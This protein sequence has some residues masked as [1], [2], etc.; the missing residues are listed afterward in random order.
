MSMEVRKWEDMN[1]DCLTNVFERVGWEALV[2]HLPLVCK[3]WYK[4]SLHPQFWKNLD[5]VPLYPDYIVSTKC[6]V[7]ENALLPDDILNLFSVETKY[8]DLFQFPKDIMVKV[9]ISRSCGL[10]TKLVV[11]Y[12][13]MVDW[14]KDF[15]MGRRYLKAEDEKPFMKL[16]TTLRSLEVL[17]LGTFGCYFMEILAGISR[18]CKNF[19]ALSTNGVIFEEEA[20]AIV[21][22]LPSIKYLKLR[23]SRISHN[24][25]MVI[26][27]GCKELV[28]LDVSDCTGFDAGDEVILNLASRIKNFIS[29]GSSLL[30]I[31]DNY[32]DHVVD[33]NFLQCVMKFL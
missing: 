32:F 28:L 15:L 10:A 1:T 13:F 33:G 24:S 11:P 5:F 3:S 6:I 26:L 22:F 27:N 20:S 30:N 2:F 25:L 23:G 4:V 16:F 17:V 29:E 12:C 18:Y 14:V 7:D 21:K 31:S 8:L 9:A 19:L